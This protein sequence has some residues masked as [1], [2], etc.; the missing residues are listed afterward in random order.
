VFFIGR[1]SP[2]SMHVLLR[3]KNALPC[4]LL[5]T[6]KT[7]LTN[8]FVSLALLPQSCSFKANIEIL[9]DSSLIQLPLTYLR[10]ASDSYWFALAFDTAL[11]TKPG[12]GTLQPNLY[13]S[14][15]C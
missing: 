5:L 8:L 2:L 12:T 14:T 13:E 4:G 1:T 9:S 6:V 7:L 3:F 11:F 10:L 15:H